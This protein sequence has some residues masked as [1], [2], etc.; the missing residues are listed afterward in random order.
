M[1]IPDPVEDGVTPAAGPARLQHAVLAVA[2][3][4]VFGCVPPTKVPIETARYEAGTTYAPRMLFVLLPGN[5]DPMTVFQKKGIINAVRERGLQADMI[6]VN[7]HIG[8]YRN[9]SVF[10][11]LK[12]DVI[13]PAKAR[14]YAQIWLIGDSLGGYGSISYA[15]LYPE[16][17]TGIVLLGPFLGD[18]ELIDEIKQAGGLPAW[19]PAEADNSSMQGWNKHIWLWLKDCLDTKK[20]D[21]RVYAGYGLHDRFSYAQ[22]FL[23]SYLPP[24]QVIA[25][26]GGHDW[27]TWKKIWNMFL[28]RNIFSEQ[29]GLRAGPIGVTK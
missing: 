13:D 2:L 22:S 21:R 25:I 23:A 9:G 10:T 1:L 24:E 14:G 3:F 19:T 28:D 15:R 29:S 18:K 11:R 4:L 5:G 8:Y 7:A 16:D 17:I 26:N 27:S 6:A 20:C 12:E